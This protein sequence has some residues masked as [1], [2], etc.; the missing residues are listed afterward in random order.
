[1]QAFTI[2]IKRSFISEL[3]YATE[4][5]PFKT[6]AVWRSWNFWIISKA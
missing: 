3:K 4:T 2:Q 5:F 1:M 6:K